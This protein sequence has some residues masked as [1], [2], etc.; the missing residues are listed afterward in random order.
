MAAKVP[1]LPNQ[2]KTCYFS[3]FP[4]NERASAIAVYTSGQYIGLAFLTPALM[5]IQNYMGWRGLFFITGIIGLLWAVFS[6]KFSAPLIPT[7]KAHVL[8]LDFSSST[9]SGFDIDKSCASTGS[10]FRL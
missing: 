10:L 7:S 5:A 4:E 6:Y 2:D 1:G 8:Y 3:L 9:F